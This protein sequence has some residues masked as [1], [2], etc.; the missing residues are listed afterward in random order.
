VR[1]EKELFIGFYAIRKLLETFKVSDSTRAMTFDL[2]WSPCLKSVDYL[3]AHRID[4]LF[5]LKETATET[6]DIGFL[7][8]Q[9]VHSYIFVP[10]E[11]EQ[12]EIAGFYVTSDKSRH[13]KLYFVALS[14]VLSA[15]HTVGHDYPTKMNLKR[16]RKTGQWEGTVQ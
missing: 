10:A 3:N 8:N 16:N 11:G 14:Q 1:V 15:F 7:C 6:R 4:E 13:E 9:F 5:D 2:Q 12:G